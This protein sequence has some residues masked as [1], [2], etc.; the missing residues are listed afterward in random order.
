MGSVHFRSKPILVRVAGGRYSQVR[1]VCLGAGG[2]E[3]GGG[4]G[5]EEGGGEQ[6]ARTSAGASASTLAMPCPKL[7]FSLLSF[8]AP[9]VCLCYLSGSLFLSWL[10]VSASL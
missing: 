8:H 7:P 1:E 4:E 2:K 6:V 5:R 9:S 3:E 10:P